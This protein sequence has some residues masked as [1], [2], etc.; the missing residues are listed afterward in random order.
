MTGEGGLLGR[1]NKMATWVMRRT[2]RQAAT[3]GIPATATRPRRCLPIPGQWKSVCRRSCPAVRH[4]TEGASRTRSSIRAAQGPRLKVV[5]P[6]SRRRNIPERVMTLV[7]DTAS[8]I[9]AYRVRFA[10]HRHASSYR[11][12]D[13]ERRLLG[14]GERLGEEEPARTI[15][16][17]G[18]S[19][20][21]V[22]V[23]LRAIGAH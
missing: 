20:A 23:E 17:L 22:T 16:E 3:A 14:F 8:G 10:V 15:C 11:C 13:K 18:S 9:S 1:L 6:R 4:R 19:I 12:D 7:G 5:R 21:R 2:T